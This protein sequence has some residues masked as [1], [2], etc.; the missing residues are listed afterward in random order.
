[1]QK[2]NLLWGSLIYYGKA[3]STMGKLNL[4]VV[5]LGFGGWNGLLVIWGGRAT[6]GLLAGGQLERY[7]FVL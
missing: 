6:N 1:M 7:L 4:R 3:K 2:L 5:V